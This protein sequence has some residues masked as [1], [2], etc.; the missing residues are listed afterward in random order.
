[1]S[2]KS[3]KRVR[4][5][6]RPRRYA[7]TLKIQATLVETGDMMDCSNRSSRIGRRGKSG[8]KGM[9]LLL[10]NHPS[11]KPI[12]EIAAG[13]MPDILLILKNPDEHSTVL[14]DLFRQPGM[15]W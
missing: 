9:S 15:P 1:M 10:S 14:H 13:V 11:N 5:N 3:R 7:K 2:R 12:T 8:R 6:K 4:E